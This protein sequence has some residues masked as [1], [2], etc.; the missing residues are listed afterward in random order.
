MLLG[1]PLRTT[2]LLPTEHLLNTAVLCVYSL[3]RVQLFATLRTV[4]RQAPLST[5]ILQVR[6]L[7]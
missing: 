3:S 4:A 6:I 2:N 7:E 1:C 5:G